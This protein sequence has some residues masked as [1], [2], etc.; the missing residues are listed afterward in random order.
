MIAQKNPAFRSVNISEIFL[1]STSINQMDNI[2]VGNSVRLNMSFVRKM[3]MPKLATFNE[4][5]EWHSSSENLKKI[6]IQHYKTD[7]TSSSVW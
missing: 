4:M 3:S 2:R 7:K 5:L 1:P 6:N